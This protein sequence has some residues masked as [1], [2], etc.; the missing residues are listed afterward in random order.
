MKGDGQSTERIPCYCALCISRCGAIAVLE[1]GRFTSLE[2]DPSHPTGK[3]L[4]AKGRAAPELVYHPD[5]LRYPL[6]RTRPKGDPDPGWQRISWDEALDLTA[7]R[8]RQIAAEHGPESVAFSAVSPSTSASDDSVDW[9][10]RLMNAFGS[11]NLCAS[12]ELCGWGRHMATLYTF[13]APVPGVYM[14]DLEQ[15]GCILFWGYNPNLARLVHAT[16]T[17]D[18]LKRGARLIVV[19]PRRIGIA[20]KADSWL[21]VRPGSDGALA[22]GIAGVMLERGWY[23]GD[24]VRRWTNGPLLVRADNGRLL[25]ASDLST[26][27]SAQQY[28]A[29]SEAGGR[30][31]RYDPTARSYEGEPAGL[32][33]F[34]EFPINTLQGEVRCR[35]AFQLTADLCR[36]YTPQRVEAIC[37]VEP[38]QLEETARLL[39]DARPVAY[40]AWSGVE[41]QSNSTQIARAIAQLYALTG[42]LDAAGGNVLFAVVPTT[43]ITG[44]HLLPAEQRAKALGLSERPLGPSRFQHVTSDELYRAILEQEPYG[45]HGLVGFGANLLLS[46][47]DG[48][49]GRQ[50][51]A[52]LDFYVHADLFMNPTAELADVVLPVAGAFEREALKVGFQV[53]A[54]AHSLVQFRQRVVEPQG[55]A[56]SDTE[57]VFDLAQRLGLGAHFWEGNIEAAYRHQL[58]PSDISLEDLRE[59]PGGV[60]ASVQTRYRKF[61]EK[62]NDVPRGF[63]TPTGKI[64]FYSETML[65]HGYSPLPDYEEPLVSPHSQPDLADRYPLILTCAKHTLFCESQHRSLPSLRRRARDPEVELHPSAAAE[66]DIQP[67]DWVRIETPAGSVRARARLDDTLAPNVVCGQHGWWQACPEIDAPGYDPFSSDG[68]NFNLIIG[69]DAIDPVSGSVPHRAYL[70]QIRRD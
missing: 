49:R 30:P 24:F 53:S 37:G 33:L 21:Q 32:A 20:K 4:C 34:G 5:R 42:S 56:R 44:R 57:I 64:E 46:H 60:H 67:G 22:L 52:A 14:P 12:M 38:G 43:D 27:G 23:D 19:D 6:R 69:N 55:E 50:A 25:R 1:D 15:A 66:R 41:M 3:A 35:P 65:E 61:A 31:I 62:E 13:G 48:Q 2:P 36:S 51:L 9:I 17:V 26:K 70:C 29:W 58:A 8:L 47:A 18:A 16:A 11:P 59:N 45:V 10:E 63:R 54:E 40:Y 39:W 28:V 7:A 68:A